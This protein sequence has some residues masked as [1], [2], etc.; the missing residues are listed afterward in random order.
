MYKKSPATTEV[1]LTIPAFGRLGSIVL[2]AFTAITNQEPSS[3]SLVY[4]SKSAQSDPASHCPTG[5]PISEAE[6]LCIFFGVL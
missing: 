1:T 6:R 5:V 2:T 4:P 3:L